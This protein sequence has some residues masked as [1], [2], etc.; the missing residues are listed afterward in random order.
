MVLCRF[1]TVQCEL[2]LSEVVFEQ[3][4]VERE[5]FKTLLYKQL[6]TTYSLLAAARL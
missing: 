6:A 5:E 1:K 4:A 3:Q 2:L